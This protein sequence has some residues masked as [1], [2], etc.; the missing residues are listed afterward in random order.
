M[1][2]I[3]YMRVLTLFVFP[4][5][6]IAVLTACGGDQSGHTGHEKAQA[7]R[8]YTDSLYA[9]V[10]EAHDAVMPKMGKIRLAQKTATRLLDSLNQTWLTRGLAEPSG[11]SAW[12][13]SLQELIDQLNYADYAMD[14]WMTE[15]NLDSAQQPGEARR[16]YLE[17]EK[18]K[19]ERVKE[20]I[21]RSLSQ[22]DSLFAAIK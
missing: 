20:S 8:T 22:A 21:L 1:L 3:F 5:L 17:S 19:V 15:F 9:S 12:K 10:W 4:F 11:V 6:C 16:P 13:R 18:V 14:R 2:K 7:P